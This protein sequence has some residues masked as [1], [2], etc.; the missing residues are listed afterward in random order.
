MTVTFT[1]PVACIP[2]PSQSTS[3]STSPR[4]IFRI[5]SP[6]RRLLP[7]PLLR[8]FAAPPKGPP[9]DIGGHRD[10][11]ESDD[12]G[13]SSKGYSFAVLQ[14]ILRRLRKIGFVVGKA[15]VFTIPIHV[16]AVGIYSIFADESGIIPRPASGRRSKELEGYLKELAPELEGKV[17]IYA[18]KD[19]MY[20]EAIT[21]NG[22]DGF[23]EM[24]ADV[25][26]VP[27]KEGKMAMVAHETAHIV[28]KH[29]QCLEK[30]VR[31]GMVW[32][33]VKRPWYGVAAVLGMLRPSGIEWT[34]NAVN[35]WTNELDR[36]VLYF[37]LGKK[38]Y[39]ELEADSKAMHL[40]DKAGWNLKD[41][42]IGMDMALREVDKMSTHPFKHERLKRIK[43]TVLEI[44]SKRRQRQFYEGIAKI[45]KARFDKEQQDAPSKREQRRREKEMKK[46]L[47]RTV[48]I[49]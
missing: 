10:R 24:Y 13:E 48:P 33:F 26:L 41:A 37:I 9:R 8:S 20:G 3:P 34:V 38:R 49:N 16:G 21:V 15:Y 32:W 17:H 5:L 6:L 12:D 2:N 45:D 1:S 29:G 14:T 25:G 22:E 39:F 42:V 44:E 23:M 18:H 11:D 43:A 47:S 46:K 35:R 36:E 7:P 30:L 28:E 4:Q 31:A 19:E 40:M 27:T